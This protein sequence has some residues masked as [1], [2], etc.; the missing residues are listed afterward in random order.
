MP[1]FVKGK[2]K[3]LQSS[4]DKIGQRVVTFIRDCPLRG[5]LRYIGEEKDVGTIMGLEMVSNLIM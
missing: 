5:T 3:H 1:C 4:Q 2:H